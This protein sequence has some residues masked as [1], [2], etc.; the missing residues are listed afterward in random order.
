MLTRY[1]RSV[2]CHKSC[3]ASEY[4]DAF[5]QVQILDEILNLIFKIHNDI[6]K[7]N[8]V[9]C[10]IA[11]C[12]RNAYRVQINFVP[13]FKNS[14]WKKC[15]MRERSWNVLHI[16]NLHATRKLDLMS[17]LTPH[18]LDILVATGSS[19]AAASHSESNIHNFFSFHFLS[20]FFCEK[21]RNEGFL[22][23]FLPDHF[24]DR[25]RF[26]KSLQIH[27][28]SAHSNIIMQSLIVHIQLLR[29]RL[30]RI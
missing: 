8:R 18:C 17:I 5:I 19:A 26:F 29:I 25:E 4:D 20:L 21:M 28:F 3:T 1:F 12:V 13:S 9:E 30:L 22:C 14:F 16:C 2:L 24:F 10:K 7:E 27:S 23:F 15:K 6:T 11:I